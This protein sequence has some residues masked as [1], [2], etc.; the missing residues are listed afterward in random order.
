MLISL[1]PANTV[2]IRKRFR[3]VVR[4]WLLELAGRRSGVF[5]P[6]KGGKAN[7]KTRLCSPPCS[8]ALVR[9]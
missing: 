6:G 1:L 2:K 8:E 9:R 5:A 3:D 7:I 4:S